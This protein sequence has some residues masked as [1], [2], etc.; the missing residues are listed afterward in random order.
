[1]AVA[2]KVEVESVVYADRDFVKCHA[3]E[4][5]LVKLFTDLKKLV[6]CCSSTV[7]ELDFFLCM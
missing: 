2:A 5:E 4:I 1:M 7:L 3:V 6:K